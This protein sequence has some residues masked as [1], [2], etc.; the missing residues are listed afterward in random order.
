MRLTT[1][2]QHVVQGLA[3]KRDLWRK[4]VTWGPGHWLDETSL[5]R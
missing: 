3:G 2:S 5:L 4:Q 1:I